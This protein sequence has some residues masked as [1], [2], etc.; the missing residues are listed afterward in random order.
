MIE[1]IAFIQSPKAFLHATAAEI[2]KRSRKRVT[3]TK[4]RKDLQKIA[5]VVAGHRDALIRQKVR[6]GEGGRGPGGGETPGCFHTTENDEGS[7]MGRRWCGKSG[8]SRTAGNDEGRE[9]GR[10]GGGTPG[11]MRKAASERGR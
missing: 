10:G 3:L 9:M 6:G 11:W 5:E 8:C 4:Q 7:E 1:G 2:S